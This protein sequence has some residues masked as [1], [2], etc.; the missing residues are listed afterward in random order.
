MNMKQAYPVIFTPDKTGFTAFIPDFNINTQG[1]DIDDA[2]EM[3]RD[4]I[5]LMGIDMEDDKKPLPKPCKLEDIKKDTCDIVTLIDVDFAEYRR[6]L[7]ESP[8]ILS[9]RTS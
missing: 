6:K 8:N 5:G 9:E 7:K 2:I 1:D 4:A 3:S